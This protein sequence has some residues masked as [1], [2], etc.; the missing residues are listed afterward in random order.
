MD[1]FDLDMASA[2]AEANKVIPRASEYEH[3]LLDEYGLEPSKTPDYLAARILRRNYLGF[4]EGDTPLLHTRGEGADKQLYLGRDWIRPTNE[5]TFY[6]L[7][8]VDFVVPSWKKALVSKIL[9]DYAPHLE[10]GKIIVS[11]ALY[12]DVKEG[13]LKHSGNKMLPASPFDTKDRKEDTEWQESLISKEP[14]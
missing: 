5:Q 11:D 3:H 12:W 6:E 1:D 7:S 4:L 2:I 10:E 8:G 9:Y 13:K 14:L